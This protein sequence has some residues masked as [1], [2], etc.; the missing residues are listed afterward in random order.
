MSEINEEEVQNNSEN[1]NIKQQPQ[2]V[3]VIDHRLLAGKLTVYNWM[4]DTPEGCTPSEIVEVR[5]KNT[6]KGFYL[7]NSNLK[8]NI[9]DIVAVEAALGHDIGIVS[10]TGEL[11]REQ[12]RLKKVDLERNPLKK[13]YRKAKPHDIEKWQLLPFLDVVGFC[14]SVYL[15]QGITFQVD[16]F[17]SHLFPHECSREDTIPMSCPRA[18]STATMSPIFSFRLLLFK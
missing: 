13:I 8:L 9:G 10:L 4:E 3:P 7:N 18:A 12:M 15:F 17:Q 11:V 16:F 14:L 2:V 1:K 5:F 6:R